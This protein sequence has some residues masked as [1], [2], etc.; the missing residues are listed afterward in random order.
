MAL[1][2]DVKAALEADREE[3]IRVLAEHRVRPTPDD[4]SGGTSLG[5]LSAAPSFRFETEDGET[6]VSDR[7]TRSAVVDA[8]GVHSEEDCEAVNEEIAAHAAWHD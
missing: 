5:G 4:Q 3:L 8:L 7:Q 2:E 6:A 1:Q